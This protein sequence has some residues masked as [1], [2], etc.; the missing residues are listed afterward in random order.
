MMFIYC[1]T[2]KKISLDLS[3]PFYKMPND[4]TIANMYM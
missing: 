4:R 2:K 1:K 3:L